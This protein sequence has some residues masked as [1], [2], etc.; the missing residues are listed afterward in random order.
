MKYLGNYAAAEDVA[1]KA[2]IEQ[3]TKGM[4]TSEL[5]PRYTGNYLYP[6][7][8]SRIVYNPVK[9]TL[10][11][12]RTNV[13]VGVTN[14]W[15]DP[16]VLTFTANAGFLTYDGSTNKIKIGNPS[17]D[18]DMLVGFYDVTKKTVFVNTP[19]LN[20][21]VKKIACLGDSITFGSGAGGVNGWQYHRY[22]HEWCIL[23]GIETTI[24]NLG[25]GGTTVSNGSNRNAN[26]FCTRLDTVPEDADVLII[27]GGTND[28]GHN[29]PLGN[30]ESTDTK[31]F[32]GAYKYLLNW[33]AEHRPNT[34]LLMLTPLKR[35][36]RSSANT[37]FVDAQKVRN[38]KGHLLPDY[39]QAVRELA[40]DY[41]I[42]CVDLF[43]ESGLNPSLEVVRQNFMPDGLHP[44]AEGNKRIY[45]K[46]LA[47]LR[48][49]L[50]YD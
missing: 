6:N 15:V 36:Y 50:E 42:P 7:G 39:V 22:V 48:P 19:S 4:M 38:G 46:I 2:D 26:A 40:A 45:P 31:T 14:N 49:L 35:Y 12:P 28:Y 23:N 44:N 11:F 37:D 24:V 16:H 43:S 32:Y 8:S 5:V 9:N 34:R 27:W 13:K 20:K 25:I 1:T 41:C 21:R 33:L 17:K 29:T 3:A 30:M 18:N 10:S 47:K